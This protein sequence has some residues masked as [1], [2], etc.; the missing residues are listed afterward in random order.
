MRSAIPTLGRGVP[1]QR[2]IAMPATPPIARPASLSIPRP[3]IHSSPINP[4]NGYPNVGGAI[5]RAYATHPREVFKNGA[6]FVIPEVKWDRYP[7]QNG[8]VGRLVDNKN[9]SGQ[10]VVPVDELKGMIKDAK[11]N[12]DIEKAL[13]LDPGALGEDTLLYAELFEQLDLRESSATSAGA[14]DQFV[15]GGKTSG[16]LHEGFVSLTP[17]KTTIIASDSYTQTFK[18]VS[19]TRVQPGDDLSED[20]TGYT[21]P[22]AGTPEQ[23]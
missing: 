6:G 11:S 20:T 14:N 8:Y 1:G 21:G 3:A 23:G 4:P 5:V 15:E 12:R 16:G 18:N 13:G 9:A 7:A 10:F 19:I 2:S 17:L 22:L